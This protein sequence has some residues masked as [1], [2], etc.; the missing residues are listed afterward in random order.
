MFQL[1]SS[2]ISGANGL[3]RS[4]H[5]TNTATVGILSWTVNLPIF[6]GD[7]RANL[8]LSQFIRAGQYFQNKNL[9]YRQN[10]NI[11]TQHFREICISCNNQSEFLRPEIEG[12]VSQFWKISSRYPNL[13]SIGC[14]QARP[15]D[16]ST[17]QLHSRPTKPWRTLLTGESPG[18]TRPWTHSMFQPH[19]WSIDDLLKC[20]LPNDLGNQPLRLNLEGW[21][22]S[23]GLHP[24]TCFVGQTTPPYSSIG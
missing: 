19:C 8:F 18:L 14:Q 15:A 21:L 3:L 2:S 7:W 13:L 5:C 4:N 1:L 16:L 11:V 17:S 6:L 9:R 20:K 12:Q 23:R 24:L 22:V 10:W